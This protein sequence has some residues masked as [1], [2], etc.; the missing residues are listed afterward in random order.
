MRHFAIIAILLVSFPFFLPAQ[1]RGVMPGGLFSAKG[2]GV[3]LSMHDGKELRF[4]AD[5]NGIASGRYS[6]VGF[7]SELLYNNL[8]A[9]VPVQGKPV[10]QILASP[11]VTMGYV[12]DKDWEWGL[13]AGLCGRIACCLA[14]DSFDIVFGVSSTLGCLIDIQDKYDS[15]MTLYQSGLRNAIHP[16]ISIKYRF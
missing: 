8:I 4:I 10:M 5:M 9:E 16:E 7:R 6:M 12:R 2:C 1:E 13:L 3:S 15:T 14:Y 11:G